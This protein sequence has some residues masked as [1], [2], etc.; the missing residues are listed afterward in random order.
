MISRYVHKD[1]QYFVN[2]QSEFCGEE[3][4][5]N[6]GVEQVCASDLSLPLEMVCSVSIWIEIDI[7]SRNA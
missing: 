1:I 4:R 3:H 6:L 2:V 5:I 7:S